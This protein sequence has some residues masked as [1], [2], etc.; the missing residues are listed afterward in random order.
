MSSICTASSCACGELFRGDGFAEQRLN[1]VQVHSAAAEFICTSANSVMLLALFISFEQIHDTTAADR[2]RDVSTFVAGMTPAPATDC[3]PHFSTKNFTNFFASSFTG[4]FS[5]TNRPTPGPPTQLLIS[6]FPPSTA[7]EFEETDAIAELLRNIFIGREVRQIP[8]SHQDTS[9]LC[10]FKNSDFA[11]SL[12]SPLN[13]SDESVRFHERLHL[14]GRLQQSL[15]HE[16]SS[17]RSPSPTFPDR[18]YG[19][20]DTYTRGNLSNDPCCRA[21]S[22]RHRCSL[23]SRRL[24]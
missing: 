5:A 1:L 15:V 17:P 14:A 23:T 24:A 21:R 19:Q 2:G 12:D 4:E 6:P 10:S 22:V 8:G 18:Q 11:S 16:G 13:A 7:R 20:P 9:L 3:S